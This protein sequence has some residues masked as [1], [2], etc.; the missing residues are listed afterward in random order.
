MTLI[1]RV[2]AVLDAD[3]HAPLHRVCVCVGDS[4]PELVATL[5]RM[6]QLRGSVHPSPT[7]HPQ[8][9]AATSTRVPASLPGSLP[10]SS[11]GTVG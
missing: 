1:D 11:T 2:R 4:R 9:R 7:T 6:V 10:A 5:M 8:T 3:P